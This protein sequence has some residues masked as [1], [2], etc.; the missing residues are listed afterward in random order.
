MAK[1]VTGGELKLGDVIDTWAGKK[2]IIGLKPY[3]GPLAHLWPKGAQIASFDIGSGM[4][5]PNDEPFVLAS[6]ERAA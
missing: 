2:R 3:A 5:I 1:I 4:T 6:F